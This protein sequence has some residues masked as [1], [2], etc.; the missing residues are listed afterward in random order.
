MSTPTVD[1]ETEKLEFLYPGKIPE[2]AVTKSQTKEFQQSD[3]EALC[4]N[5]IESS[6]T[7]TV[8]GKPNATIKKAPLKPIPA[9]KDP[10]ARI[11][12][13]IV[14]PLPRTQSGHRYMID[15]ISN[16]KER[17]NQA[18]I[19]VL[20]EEVKEVTKLGVIERSYSTP[21][22][23]IPKPNNT[24]ICVDYRKLNAVTKQDS[25]PITTVDMI[26]RVTQFIRL[27]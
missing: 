12:I 2:C 27:S 11:T 7:S 15:C 20:E 23:I 3:N 1:K 4:E 21:V 13:D 24:H 10:F 9:V 14:G 25:H 22:V 17:L 16:F 8:V 19:T 18:K 6:S 26:D 5:Q